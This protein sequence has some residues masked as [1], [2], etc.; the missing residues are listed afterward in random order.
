MEQNGR[1]VIDIL[2]YPFSRES[3][4]KMFVDN[5]GEFRHNPWLK[6]TPRSFE[7]STADQF[8]SKM[9]NHGFSVTLISALKMMSFQTRR[10]MVDFTIEGV[11]EEIKAHPQRLK[12][13]AGY[14][15]FSIKESLAE[16]ERG[17]KEFDCR[18]V[19]IH[20]Y[21]FG[22]PLNDAR[23]YP[24]Y[25]K[26]QELDIPVSMQVGHSME[27]M[28]SG[29]GRPILLDD[30]ALAFPD[31]IIVGAHTG[32]PWVEEMI[33]LAWK[34]QNVYVG[35]DAHLP[36]YLDPSL[37]KFMKTRGQDKVLF[38]TNGVD[39][40]VIMPQFE[41]LGMAEGPKRKVLYENAARIYGL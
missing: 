8:V 34:F 25:A 33:A 6:G 30:I 20:P 18:G 22:I 3:Q 26:C 41:E 40:S 15:P 14:N 28:P 19:Y 1:Q 21:G 38:G 5:V 11:Y 24:L 7:G 2:N 23:Y 4:Q 16:I 29:T 31:L 39:P 13:L 35:I 37:V 10:L 9:D 12:I 17:V 36:R 32:W 27:L